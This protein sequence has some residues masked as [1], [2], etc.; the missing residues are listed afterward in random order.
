MQQPLAAFFVPVRKNSAYMHVLRNIVLRY[1]VLSST[2]PP[3]IL[4][5]SSLHLAFIVLANKLDTS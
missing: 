2:L 5:S 4:H 1:A 3:R